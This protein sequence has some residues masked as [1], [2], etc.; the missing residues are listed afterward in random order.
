[1][2]RRYKYEEEYL[3]RMLERIQRN[4]LRHICSF[5]K[6]DMEEYEP[7]MVRC[8]KCFEANDE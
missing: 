4:G 2:S 6:T 3:Q 5:H 1:M 7:G 8:P